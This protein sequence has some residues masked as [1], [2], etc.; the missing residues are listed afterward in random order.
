MRCASHP[1][2]HARAA[3]R[4]RSPIQIP[5]LGEQEPVLA[6]HTPFF[7]PDSPQRAAEK[8]P[9]GAAWNHKAEGFSRMRSF[10]KLQAGR[11]RPRNRMGLPP[12]LRRIPTTLAQCPPTTL[13]TRSAT[14][15]FSGSFSVLKSGWGR[16]VRKGDLRLTESQGRRERGDTLQGYRL[17]AFRSQER[18][19]KKGNKRGTAKGGKEGESSRGHCTRSLEGGVWT[20]C[21]VFP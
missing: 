19:E 18:K 9:G 17:K 11:L 16:G 2:A 12:A 8:S 5:D 3:P 10:Q 7:S 14:A 4:R 20:G 15:S 6:P 13:P 21:G 1:P